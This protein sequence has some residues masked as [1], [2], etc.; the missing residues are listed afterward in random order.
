MNFNINRVLS[1]LFNKQNENKVKVTG[2]VAIKVFKND[3]LIDTFNEKNI[4]VNQGFEFICQLLGGSNSDSITDIG[5]GTSN[6]PAV[7][8]NVA[9]TGQYSKG[10]DGVSYP[11]YN[12]I[13]FAFSL[14][15]SENNGVTIEEIGLLNT[16]GDL[17]SRKLYTIVKDNTVRVEGTWTISIS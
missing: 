8:T 10:L 13:Q 16:S 4:V 17:F 3:T 11:T 1:R 12:S 6:A 15:L 5:F 7:P 9:L 2:E 14:G